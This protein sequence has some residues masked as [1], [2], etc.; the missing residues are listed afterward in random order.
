MYLVSQAGCI[1]LLWSVLGCFGLRWLALGW[2][3]LRRGVS[4]D[5]SLVLYCVVLWCGVFVYVCRLFVWLVVRL[6]V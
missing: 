4:R 6:F 3:E 5:N 2:F 1:G